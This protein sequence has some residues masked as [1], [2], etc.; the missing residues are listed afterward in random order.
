VKLFFIRHAKAVDRMDWL[1]DDM[2]RPLSDKGVASSKSIFKALSKIYE[3]PDLVISSE[4]TRARETAESF[5]KYF[6]SSKFQ[7]SSLLNPGASCE[8][9]RNLIAQNSSVDSVALV[10]HEPDFG[11]IVSE[12]ISAGGCEIDF[13]KCALLEI[14]V[15]KNFKGILKSFIPPKVFG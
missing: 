6:P 4:A 14:E 8:S 15:D 5:M 3:A 9:I 10:G 2:L 12:L 11:R 13:K 7:K 1:K